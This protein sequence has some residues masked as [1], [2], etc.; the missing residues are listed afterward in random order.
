MDLR[1]GET[2]NATVP[3]LWNHFPSRSSTTVEQMQTFPC[4]LALQTHS[5]DETSTE[6]AMPNLENDS[7]G[8]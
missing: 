5:A 3:C 7:D 4:G 2:S 8:H 6:E 1:V